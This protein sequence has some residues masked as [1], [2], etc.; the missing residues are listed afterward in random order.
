MSTAAD[1]NGVAH[2]DRA[3]NKSP[4]KIAAISSA[5][6]VNSAVNLGRHNMVVDRLPLHVRWNTR[7]LRH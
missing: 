2:I 1:S 3:A 5:V 4:D 6:S 7:R